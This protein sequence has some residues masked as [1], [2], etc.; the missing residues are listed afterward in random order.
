VK[1]EVSDAKR[2]RSVSR[3]NVDMIGL[4]ALTAAAS[5]AAPFG[6]E[7]VVRMAELE[8]DPASV[9]RYRT[10]LAQ[11]IE[12]SVRLEPGVLS[13]QAVA[14]R[15]RP[16]EV[17]ILEIYA[18][19]AAYQAHLKAPHFLKYKMETA[20]MIRSLTPHETVPILLC[21]KSDPACP[22]H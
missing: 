22:P 8:I 16:N 11:E 13:L 18:S 15:E 20:G 12:A 3:G 2:T 9:E 6:S 10:I 4:V 5:T 17:R 1:V 7:A 19:L 21:G 14:L